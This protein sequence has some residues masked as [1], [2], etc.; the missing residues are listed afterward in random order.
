M[1]NAD[2]RDM[3]FIKQTAWEDKGMCGVGWHGGS[4]TSVNVS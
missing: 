2:K 3:D 1:R 4:L